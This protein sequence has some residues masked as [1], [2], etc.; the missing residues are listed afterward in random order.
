MYKNRI[1]GVRHFAT[2]KQ[3]GSKTNN[4]FS[5]TRDK[6]IKWNTKI[7]IDILSKLVWSV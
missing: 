3:L 1:R 5:D 4:K 7:N 6:R 2:K